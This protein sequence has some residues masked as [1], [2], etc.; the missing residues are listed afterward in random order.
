M[1]KYSLYRVDFMIPRQGYIYSRS[2]E[3]ITS[4]PREAIAEVRKIVFRETGE[5]ASR[6]K[7]KLVSL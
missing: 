1:G 3:I 6:C 7:A 4:G 5:H 2:L